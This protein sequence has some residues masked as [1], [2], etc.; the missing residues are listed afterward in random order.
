MGKKSSS[1]FTDNPVIHQ[2]SDDKNEET[3]FYN[4][5]HNSKVSPDRIFSYHWDN[6]NS[7]WSDKHL[8]VV[9]DS[10]TLSF[11]SLANREEMGYI[12][13]NTDKSGFAVHPSILLNAQDGGL[14]GVGGT[15][16]V[17][18]P[19]ARTT[20]E[21][22]AKKERNKNRYKIPFAEKERYKWFQSPRKAIDNCPTAAQYTLVGDRETDI[23]DLIALTLAKDW[24]FIYRSKNDRSL[25]TQSIYRNLYEAI[26]GW[27]SEH[28][29]SFEVAKTKERTAYE[30][31][32][33]VKFGTV[34]IQRPK[35]NP[36]K[37]LPE[38]I[39]LQVVQVKECPSTVVDDEQPIHWILLTSHPVNTIK[40][41]LQIIQWYQWRW[42]IEE[43]FRTLKTKGLNIE[44]STIETFDGL[45]N[46][47]AL[48]LLAA[49]QT[50]QM[51]QARDGKT[52]QKM[53]D[54]FFEQ[55]QHCLI[56][57]NEKV[58][59]NTEKT[60]NPFPVDTLAFATWV[61]ARLGGWNGYQ[62]SRPP[63]PITMKKGLVRFYNIMQG[64]QLR[65]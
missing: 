42:I 59:G 35:Y 47:T 39:P 25:S 21:K 54:V 48:G 28:H 26:N 24:H 56:Q 44:S 13:P 50:M 45:Q 63:G 55:E 38:Q 33:N 49:A 12:G 7:D 37:T 4:F 20:A 61:I 31:K 65:Q 22:A 32:V 53:Q 62:K 57:L 6:I 41:A 60:Q 30:A 1:K 2:L 64:F 36:D 43:L 34:V 58:Q 40:Q 27:N 51:V 8:L 16:I 46:L 9:N 18:T 19:F 29:Y 17:V 5:I 52:K 15:D 14:Y 23:Y 10:S 11:A 3:R